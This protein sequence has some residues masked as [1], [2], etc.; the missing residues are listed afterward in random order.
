MYINYWNLK[1]LPFE[2]APD[3]EF[4]YESNEHRE[5]AVRLSFAIQTRK[6]IALISGDYGSG[7]TAMCMSVLRKLDP[8]KFKTAMITNPRMDAID[9]TREIAYQFGEEINTRSKYDVLHAL[10]NLLERQY[11]AG[12]HC[13]AIIDEAQL[14]TDSSVLEDM[15]LLLNHQIEGKSLVTLVLLGQTEI[16]DM[17]RPIP[18][19]SQRIGLKFHIPN[20][21]T[22][23]I[24]PYI[25][26]R[27]KVAGGNKDI[28]DDK[29]VA[30]LERL[31]KGNPREINALCDMAMLSACLGEQKK[32]TAE[33]VI[34]AAKERS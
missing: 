29:A 9:L 30:E 7:K 10:N 25:E 33:N 28:F 19:M 17:L 2:N 3:P 16:N 13:T 12:R 23:E 26:H 22:K 14:I 15:R 21:T 20:L 8:N 34:D 4:F 32:V 24:R 11:R 6:A 31:S 5:A 18:Q 27:L 1:C